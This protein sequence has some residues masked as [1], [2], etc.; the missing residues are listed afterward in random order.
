MKYDIIDERKKVC[1]ISL[2]EA[3]PYQLQVHLKADAAFIK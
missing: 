3:H 2:I 1:F